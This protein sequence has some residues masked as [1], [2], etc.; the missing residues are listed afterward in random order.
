MIRVHEPPGTPCGLDLFHAGFVVDDIAAAMAAYT[1]A[2]GLRWAS[3]ATRVVDV[4]VACERRTAE[5]LAVY[6]V[7]G[8]PHVELIEEVS[9]DIWGTRFL[10]MNH[11]GYWSSAFATD[12]DRLQASGFAAEVRNLGPDGEPGRF[13]YHRTPSGLWIE[14]VDRAVEPEIGRWLAGAGYGQGARR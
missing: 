9:G 11:V 2:F 8:P 6:S 12:V 14:V 4:I 10:A 1:Q 5:L 13:A 7:D 3:V